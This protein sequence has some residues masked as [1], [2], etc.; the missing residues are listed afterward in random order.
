MSLTIGTQLGSHEIIALLGKGG[1]GE[2]YRARDLK[3]KREVAIKI[4]PEEFSCN[5]DRVS[6]FQREA[7]VL[8]SLNHPNIATIHDLAESNGSKYLVLELVEGETLADR[9]ARGPIPVKEALNISIQIC[10]ALEAAHERGI[11]HRDLKP[12]NV[13]LTPDGKVKVLDFGLAK[14][15]AGSPANTTVSNSPTLLSGTMGGVIIGTAAYMSPEQARGLVADQRSDIF[16]FGCILYEI[17]SGSQAFQG[18]TVSDIL[19]AVLAREPDFSLLPPDMRPWLV[20][21]VRRCLEKNPRR[22]WYSIGDVRIAIEEGQTQPEITD[23]IHGGRR[24]TAWLVGSAAGLVVAAAVL[25]FVSQ[26]RKTPPVAPLRLSAELGSGVSLPTS[27]IGNAGLALSPDGQMLAFTGSKGGKTQLYLRQLTQLDAM[28]LAETDDAVNPFFSSDGKWIGFFSNGKLR[29]VLASGGAAVT[30]ADAPSG[31]GGTWTEDG[32]IIFC[33]DL[34]QGV[35]LVRVSEGGGKVEPQTTLAKGESW[36]R[37]PQMLPGDKALLYTSLTVTYGL[38]GANIVVQSYPNG[39][40]KTL[41]HGG[42]SAR[43]V[44]SGHIVYVHDG[45]LFAVPFDLGHLE[46]KG[47]PAPV[48]GGVTSDQT[49]SAH[50]SVSDNGVVVY[51]AGGSLNNLPPI[52]WLDDAGRTSLLRS[53]GTN[54]SNPQFS[55]DGRKIAID[56]FDN[57]LDIWTYDWERDTPTRFTFDSSEDRK[58]IWFPDGKRIAFAS[59]RGGDGLNLYWQRSDLAGEPQRLTQSKNIQL[60]GSFHPSGKYLAFAENHIEARTGSDLMILPIEGNEASGWKPGQPTIFLNTPANE[61]EPMFSPDGRWIAYQSDE[62]GRYEIFVKPFPGPGGKLQVSAGGGQWPVWSRTRHELLYRDY[63]NHVMVAAY[64]TAGD[65]FS[66]DKPKPWSDKPIVPTARNRMF[67]LH[68]DGKRLAVYANPNLENQ[69]K[70]DK[71][72]FIFNFFD[73]LRRI[74]PISKK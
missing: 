19:A 63:D 45:T 21:L 73:E 54:W 11:I 61:Q 43:Y 32:H 42:Y 74:A 72:A 53:T 70:Q 20:N 13:K 16:S 34:T 39:T 12:A 24:L 4:L 56:I 33:P 10:E 48:V 69:A 28:A 15:L 29:K 26:S 55:P 30:L 27:I 6:R 25:L 1:M 60:P 23:A 7:E 71:V 37:W 9:I 41:I 65:S 57:Q 3:L 35:S 2:V 58:P 49:G 31:R 14:A 36:H 22:R 64:T 50:F 5:S 44:G 40:P 67:D 38:D 62:N 59:A 52:S 18:G 51:L 8:A 66:S 47:Q 68:P 17:L 46:L